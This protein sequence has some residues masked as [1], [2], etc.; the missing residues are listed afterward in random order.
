VGLAAEL[1]HGVDVVPCGDEALGQLG[2]P[3]QLVT[4]SLQVPL[5]H[6]GGEPEVL[7]LAHSHQDIASFS[8]GL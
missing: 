8:F 2:D 6:A 1:L 3:A 7:V 5:P 4:R